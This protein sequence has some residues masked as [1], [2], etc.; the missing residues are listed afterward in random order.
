MG[1]KG[2]GSGKGKSSCVHPGEAQTPLSLQTSSAPKPAQQDG[3]MTRTEVRPKTQNREGGKTA[4][5]GPFDAAERQ[6]KVR[7]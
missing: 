7:G 6:G 4:T 5:K 2:K 3:R 1:A